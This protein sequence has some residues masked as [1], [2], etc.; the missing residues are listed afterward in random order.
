L[1]GEDGGRLSSSE[2]ELGRKGGVREGEEWGWGKRAA[3]ERG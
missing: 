2:K 1:G 3:E